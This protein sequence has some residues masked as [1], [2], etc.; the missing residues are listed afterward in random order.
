[1]LQLTMALTI[2]VYPVNL[3]MVILSKSQLRKVVTQLRM[4]T[5]VSFDVRKYIIIYPSK[6]LFSS[7]A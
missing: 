5:K 7:V 6:V 3:I 2:D 1:M 4:V